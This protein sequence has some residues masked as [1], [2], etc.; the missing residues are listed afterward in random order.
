MERGVYKCEKLENLTLPSSVEDIKEYVF[1][2]CKSLKWVMI[3]PSV[4]TM[5]WYNDI[6]YLNEDTIL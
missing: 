4:K 5:A 1:K 6:T 3:P 2:D